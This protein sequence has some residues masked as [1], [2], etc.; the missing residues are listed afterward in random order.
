MFEVNLNLIKETRLKK[1][2]SLQEMAENIGLSDKVKYYRRESGEYKF[3]AEEIPLVCSSL[4]IPYKKIFVQKVSKIE[5][6]EVAK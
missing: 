4:G 6:F 1:G 3:K 2:Y 5:T